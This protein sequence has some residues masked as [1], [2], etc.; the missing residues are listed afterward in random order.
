MSYY[1]GIDNIRG[2]TIHAVYISDDKVYL[3]LELD[4][5]YAHFWVDGDCCSNTWIESVQ[6]P[7]LG[8]GGIIAE[9]IE[10]PTFEDAA[11]TE[12]DCVQ[13]YQTILVTTMGE[14]MVEYRNASNGYYG[15]SIHPIE[16]IPVGTNMRKVSP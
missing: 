10:H 16:K 5:G 9:I 6:L 14:M 13:V 2:R 1:S 12:D 7:A 3:T 8:M 11:S 4:D 15:G